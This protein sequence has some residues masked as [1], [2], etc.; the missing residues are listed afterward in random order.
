M[1]QEPLLSR[2]SFVIGGVRL[3]ALGSL[4]PSLGFARAGALPEPSDRVLVVVQLTGGND[5]LN[6]VIPHG[7][8]AY[9]RL[10]PTLAQKPGAV[11]RLDEHMAL[12]PLLGPLAELY[13][14]G[15]LTVAHGVGHPG[16]DRSH[17][18]SM[19]IWH[20]A[21]PFAPAGRV[22]WL[23]HL[24]DQLLAKE[25]G[26]LPALSV[27]GRGAMLSMRGAT[28]IPPTVPDDRG[29]RLAHSSKQV[30][31][32]RAAIVAESRGG[33]G[34]LA[35]LRQ[36]ARTSYRAAERMANLVKDSSAADYP[37]TPLGKELRL[38]AQLIRG[39]FGTRIFHVSMGGFDTHASQAPVHH[40]LLE[41]LGKAL[42]AFQ[43]DLTASGD[44]PRVATMV[45]SEFGR[46]ARENGSRGTDHG[47]AN[48]VLFLGPS[49]KGGQVGQR[50]DLG[51]LVNGDVPE[52]TDFRG[53]YRQFE[54][55]WM[56]L[57]RFA[58]ERVD[59]PA[60]L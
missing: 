7:Q 48:P 16:A 60:I 12:H 32:E 39:G 46:R 38:V 31:R 45:F 43:A 44:A 47:R 13:E 40:P 53:L 41:R 25:P 5:G 18:R 23:G 10:R 36:T 57:R 59:A 9:Y 21:E 17:F 1:K 26:S 49:L 29:F 19:E 11:H 34:D 28:A 24:C 51:K 42:G 15:A 6:T 2:R 54:E 52:T 3:T 50:P 56:G 4:A 30:A 22:G 58:K 33:G 14:E 27:G 35:F 20:T 8:D 55:D 37:N